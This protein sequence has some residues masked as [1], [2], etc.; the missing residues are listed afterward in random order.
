MKRMLKLFSVMLALVM[1][2]SISAMAAENDYQNNNVLGAT[3]S[4]FEQLIVEIQDIKDT[5]SD[6]TE[7][8]IFETMNKQHPKS[9]R[10]VID[11]W[12]VLTDSEKKLCIRYPYDALKVNTAKNVATSQTEKNFGINGLGDRSDAFRHGIWNAEMTILIGKEKAELF[13]TAHED[14]DVTGKES[15]GYPKTA[16]RDMDMHNNEVGRNIGERNKDVT[17][18]EMADI[19]YQEIYSETTQFVWLHE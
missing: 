12:N 18:N 5:Y 13:A 6:Y 19:I 14:K 11:I 1:T 8:M 2:F 9:T 16:H 17:E 3:Q 15:D 7:K 10:G 4:E